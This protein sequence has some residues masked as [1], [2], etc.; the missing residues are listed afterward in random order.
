MN[1]PLQ[2]ISV[3]N[4][5]ISKKLSQED[6]TSTRFH[7]ITFLIMP[8]QL[9]LQSYWEITVISLKPLLVLRYTDRK[10]F[11]RKYLSMS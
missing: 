1:F 9:Y 5:A 7:A 6:S 10:K 3:P 11:Q 8:M 2:L 4:V